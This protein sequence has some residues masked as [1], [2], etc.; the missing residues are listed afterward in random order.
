MIAQRT[1]EWYK[2]RIGKFTAS[3]F[4]NLLTRPADKNALLSKSALNCIEKAAAQLFYNKFYERPDNDATRWGL[5]H[6]SKAIL[7]FSERTGM[8]VKDI[9]YIEHPHL[10][11]VGA[12]PDTQ[13]I[14]TAQPNKLIIAQIKC[15]YNS[16]YHTDYLNK[17][18]DT[19]SLK[20]KKPEY[21]WQIQGEIWVTG[22]DHS[23]FVS[24]DPRMAGNDCLHY[25]KINRDNDAIVQLE[26]TI[27]QAIKLRDILLDDFRNGRKLPK[28]LSEYY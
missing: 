8:Q 6:E 23:Y 24:F 25:I 3:N 13:V 4:S 14:D 5:K 21:Y 11:S 19:Q 15:P 28:P 2:M 9:G 1:P 18:S 17:I 26:A 16:D 27:N 20:K 7:I 10:I 22:A 12:T